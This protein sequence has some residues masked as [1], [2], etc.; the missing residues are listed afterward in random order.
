MSRTIVKRIALLGVNE[1]QSRAINARLR[2]AVVVDSVEA[3][4]AI[5]VLGP[6][7]GLPYPDRPLLVSGEL[8]ATVELAR[9]WSEFGPSHFRTVNPL[10]YSPSHLLIRQQIETGKL[11]EIGLLRLHR[12]QVSPSLRCDLDLL[13]WYFPTS[14]NLV[15]AIEQR[16]LGLQ[17]HFGFPAGGMAM[18]DFVHDASLSDRYYS[19]S[20]IG[21]AGAAYADDHPNMQLFF[22]KGAT[23]VLR[24]DEGIV[25]QAAMVQDF[26]DDPTKRV[27]QWSRIGLWYRA[28]QESL[29]TRQA[30]ALPERSGDGE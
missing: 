6:M 27:S 16:D 10:R 25:T 15:Y 20:V 1:T 30:I 13:A 22:T 2:G 17:V 3:S 5:A 14:P 9:A 12:W 18:L 4:D 21:S 28:I 7:E 24:A 26:V 19:L 11:G 23:Q 29:R 8:D